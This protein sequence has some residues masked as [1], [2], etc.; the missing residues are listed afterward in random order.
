M[1]TQDRPQTSGRPGHRQ[2]P[3]AEIAVLALVLGLGA[4]G[5]GF[6]LNNRQPDPDFAY[7]MK[8]AQPRPLRP[9]TLAGAEGP[10][11]YPY[12]DGR[13]S[14]MFFG[15]THCPDVCPATLSYLKREMKDLASR[16]SQFRTV[17][18]S[19]DPQRDKPDA[20]QRFATYFDPGFIGLTGDKA[21]LDQLTADA[22]AAYFMGAKADKGTGDYD[23]THSTSIYVV[24]PKGRVVAVYG[25][26]GK[27]GRLAQD[28]HFLPETP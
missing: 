4:F 8:M 23:V 21:A 18:I 12:K 5:A 19:V 2:R 25:G 14:L 15:Y 24:D 3:S 28:F 26:D 7:G 13:W 22:G 20:L 9:V 27:P 11:S 10:V 17:F 1:Q 16:R 6:W